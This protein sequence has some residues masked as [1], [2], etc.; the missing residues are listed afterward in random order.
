MS[1]KINIAITGGQCTGKSVTAAAL[2][3]HLKISGLDYDL[4]GEENRKLY[5]EFGSFQSVFERFY[6]WRQQEREEL[7]S[8]AN[9]GFITDTCLFH[10]YASA[11]LHAKT[12]RDQMAVRELYRMCYET[13]DRYQLIVMAEDPNELTFI[14]DPCRKSNRENSVRKHQLIQTFVEHHIPGSLLLVKGVL[15]NRIQQIEDRM[16]KMGK[17]FKPLPY[18]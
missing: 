2:F 8:N 18:R 5:K 11:Y 16:K 7:R 4:I 12:P 17:E 14:E 13:K 3:S 6:M 9:D 15:E 10:F 1:D